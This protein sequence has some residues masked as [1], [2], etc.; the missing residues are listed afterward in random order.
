MSSAGH[1]IT[2]RRRA[3]ICSGPGARI[4]ALIVSPYAKRGTVD[5]TQYDTASI[6]RLMIRRFDLQ[7]LPGIVARD[8][9]LA[10]HGEAPLG[11]LTAALDLTR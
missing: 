6:L 10:E 5:H 2:S 7:S 1:G 3:A 4:P 11:D 9:A 8:R